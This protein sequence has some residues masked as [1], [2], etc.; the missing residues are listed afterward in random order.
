MPDRAIQEPAWKK[1]K[2]N[3]G[4]V[5]DIRRKIQH[6]QKTV[7]RS[8]M[9]ICRVMGQSIITAKLTC[10]QTNK[11]EFFN[12]GTI[13]QALEQTPKATVTARPGS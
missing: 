2:K 4:G 10:E 5:F 13:L 9:K 6:S 3:V 1:K 8:S 7:S 11:N 12:K